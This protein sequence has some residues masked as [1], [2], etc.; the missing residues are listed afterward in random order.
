[1]QAQREVEPTTQPRRESG[2]P[3]SLSGPGPS[4]PSHGPGNNG[5]GPSSSSTTTFSVITPSSISGN[6]SSHC[7]PGPSV[8]DL[9]SQLRAPQ[10][11]ERPTSSTSTSNAFPEGNRRSPLPLDHTQN[12]PPVPPPQSAST[13]VAKP[14]LQDLRAISFQQALPHISQLMEDPHVVE[15]LTKVSDNIHAYMSSLHFFSVSP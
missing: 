15:S 13:H 2:V 6:S 9:L 14:L 1:M 8:A 11:L 12:T 5:A 10:S 4:L 7:A 3:S